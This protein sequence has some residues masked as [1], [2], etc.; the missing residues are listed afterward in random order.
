MARIVHSLTQPSDAYDPFVQ[1]G[2]VR[3]VDSILQKLNTTFQQEVKDE[4]EAVHIFLS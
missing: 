4:V 3:D 2:I 1:Q